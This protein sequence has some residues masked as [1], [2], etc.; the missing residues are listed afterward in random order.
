M[1][2][3]ELEE[4]YRENEKFRAY[5]NSD[6]TLSKVYKVASII[7]GFPRQIGT[8][9]AGIVMCKKDLDEVIPLT[10]SD[11]MYLTGYSMNYLEELGLLKMDFLGIRNLTIIMNVMDMVYKTRGERIEFNDIPLDDN[12]VYKIG[13]AHV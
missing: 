2:H 1:S 3:K 4:F 12:D 8:H 6:E 9:A 13:R 10:K 7:E 11:D 5:I